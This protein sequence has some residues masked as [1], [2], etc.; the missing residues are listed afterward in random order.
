[1]SNARKQHSANKPRHVEY[2]IYMSP[3][4]RK[5]IEKA[6]RKSG[7]NNKSA[8]GRRLISTGLTATDPDIV[9]PEGGE[10]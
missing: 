2:R 5:M 1:M 6:R 3:K 9:F 10:E 4:F 7:E 8:F